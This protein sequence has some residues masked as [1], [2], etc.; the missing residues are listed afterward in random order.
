[1]QQ[2]FRMLTFVK[3]S[4][5][6]P[7]SMSHFTKDFIG[8]IKGS[9]SQLYRGSNTHEY[10]IYQIEND[11]IINNISWYPESLLTEC[12]KQNRKKSEEMIEQYNLRNI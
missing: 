1:M 10:S 2:K 7:Q 4:K 5:E 9:Y 11:K 3:V 12:K 6:M 8:I